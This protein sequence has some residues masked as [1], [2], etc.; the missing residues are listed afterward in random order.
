MSL[1]LLFVAITV[2]LSLYA[3]NNESVF[4]RWMMNPYN[5]SHNKEYWRFITSG[6]IH[7]D[8]GHLIFNMFALYSFGEILE[9]T[10]GP[11]FFLPLYL[12][13]IVVSDIPTY[14][15]NRN[16]VNYN[17]LGASGGVS[18][19]VFAG[20]I[21]YPLAKIYI[22]FIPIGIPGFIF[23]ALY[24]FYSYYETRRG[25]SYVN[26]S[27]HLWGALFGIL[28]VIVLF[29]QALPSFVEQIKEWHF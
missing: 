24:L 23:G 7:A 13:G 6:F 9:M 19:V 29:P 11:A 28:Y 20:I 1:T 14:L 3:W 22:F 16:N 25:G 5:V 27:A 12:L 15:N 4:H 17:S 21:F 18:A 26:H 10:I 8:W 2:G